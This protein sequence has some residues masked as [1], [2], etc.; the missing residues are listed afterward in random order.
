MAGK[1]ELKKTKS[2]KYLLILIILAIYL[3]VMKTNFLPFV[4]EAENNLVTA[5]IQGHPVNK[6]TDHSYFKSA[7][8]AIFL[9]AIFKNLLP[10]VIYILEMV[11]APGSY[12]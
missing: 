9:E 11:D 5:V 2:M 6:G 3:I 12:S 1:E 8:Y 4:L 10:F 7:I